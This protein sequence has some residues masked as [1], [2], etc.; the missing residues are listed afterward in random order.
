MAEGD[1]PGWMEALKPDLKDH[2]GL[3]QFEGPDPLSRAF[4]EASGKVTALEEQLQGSVKIPGKTATD[5]ERATFH[6]RLGRPEKAEG[7]AFKKPNLPEGVPYHEEMEM[8]FRTKAHEI[9][10]T[11]AQAESLHTFW[12]ENELSTIKKAQELHEE[13]KKDGIK[14]LEELWGDKTA[15]NNERAK[16]GRQAFA[17]L[18][19][20]EDEGAAIIKW[21]DESGFADEVP[22]IMI[23]SE[24]GKLVT[25]DGLVEGISVTKP[26]PTLGPDG[27][28]RLTFPSMEKK[29]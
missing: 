13:H 10:L 28:P 11:Q 1:R 7:Y 23:F 6:N 4:L 25:E 17:K 12:L 15:G 21:M 16:R 5:E 9:G 22:I 8:S 20:P 24:I 29:K 19:S 27:R 26:K 18:V 14:K 2:E 3:R